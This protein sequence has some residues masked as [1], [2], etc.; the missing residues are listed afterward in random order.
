MTSEAKLEENYFFLHTVSSGSAW[1]ICNAA[2]H[3]DPS[4]LRIF[5]SSHIVSPVPAE[6]RRI[7][8]TV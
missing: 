3:G 5:N 4:S 6:N 1:S 8:L 2:F 7:K